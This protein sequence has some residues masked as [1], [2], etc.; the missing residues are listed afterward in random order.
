MHIHSNLV[1]NFL[2]PFCSPPWYTDL[3]FL[4]FLVRFSTVD[5]QPDCQY[6]TPDHQYNTLAGKVP[7]DYAD[8]T[9]RRFGKG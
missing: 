8:T 7:S 9:R 4:L 3:L 1:L 6:C 5:Q 2:L